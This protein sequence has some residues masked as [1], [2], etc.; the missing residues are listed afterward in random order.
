MD[1]G[2]RGGS[3][4]IASVG[5]GRGGPAGKLAVAPVEA[6]PRENRGPQPSRA[7]AL[8]FMLPS[9]WWR[10]ALLRRMLALADLSA[11]G[12]ATALLLVRS[13]AGATEALGPVLFLPVWILLAKLHGLYDRDQRAMRH[14]TV[15]ELPSIFV[16]AITGTAGAALV[17][18]LASAGSASVVTGIEAWALAAGGGFALRSLARQVWRRLTPPEET[19]IMG[20]GALAHATRRK[21]QLFPDMH[22]RLVGERDAVAPGELS[23]GAPGLGHADRVI[24]ALQTL[25]EELVAELLDYCRRERIKLSIVPPVRGM[26]GTA[27][28]LDQVADLPLV[29]YNTWDVARSTLLLKR[30]VDLAVAGT[31]LALLGPVC[32]L[33]ALGIRLD[34]PGPVVFT[35]R[36]TGKGGRPFSIFKFRTMVENAE[37]LLSDLVPFETLSEPVFKLED[38]PRVTRVGRVLRRT[39]LDELPQLVNVLRGEMSLVGP[40]PEQVELVERYGPEERFRLGVK[41][42]LTGPM[43]VYGRGHLSFEERL[44]VDRDYIEN[45]SIGRDLRILALTLTALVTGRGAF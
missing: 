27:V 16:W 33:V 39:S 13:G 25:E 7:L 20:T 45:L 3:E 1:R 36:R 29:Q 38:D 6:V 23:D 15:D 21:L 8:A 5:R 11:A 22:L 37:D 32:L 41:P 24:L 43:Q 35:Q 10:D 31:A 40:R 17:V 2:A 44:A 9:A 26:F 12:L 4:L 30:V 19:L 18:S 14:L 28:R 42:G 34:S